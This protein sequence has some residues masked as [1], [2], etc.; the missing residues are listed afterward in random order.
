[1]ATWLGL[2]LVVMVLLAAVGCGGG[3]FNNPKNAQPVFTQGNTSA[4][5]YTA[6]VYYTPQGCTTGACAQAIASVDFSVG[7]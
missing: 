1:M 2:F 7:Q 3:S 5:N 4:G 6:V